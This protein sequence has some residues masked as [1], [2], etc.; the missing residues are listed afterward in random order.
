[1]LSDAVSGQVAVTRFDGAEFGPVPRL[2]IAATR[3]TNEVPD[4]RLVIVWVVAVERNV[5]GA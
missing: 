5:R 1:M 3:K 2:L 4:V